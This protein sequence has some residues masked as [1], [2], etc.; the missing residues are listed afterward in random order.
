[1]TVRVTFH[2][3]CDRC[4]APYVEKFLKAGDKVPSPKS[5]G[6]IIHQLFSSED[7]KKWSDKPIATLADLCEK[8]EG[9]VAKALET[10]GGSPGKAVKAKTKTGK[11]RGRPSKAE[12][13]A[14]EA[15]KAE[16]EAK[17]KAE[18]EKPKVEEYSEPAPEAKAEPEPVIENPEPEPVA[19]EPAEVVDLGLASD[20]V[21]TE[22]VEV[23]EPVAEAAPED[24]FE[25]RETY[26]DPDTGDIKD[27]HTGEILEK[28][29][30]ETAV[31]SGDSH[32]F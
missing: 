18:A 15:K 13:A 17:A 20:A 25:G 21:S 24:P 11:K 29:V 1:M 5:K 9:V 2:Q 31:A 22:P 8:C 32:P 4:E 14:R 6:I 3:T 16:E 19:E 7:G 12:I 28:R 27:V 30:A 10:I 23:E 26:E